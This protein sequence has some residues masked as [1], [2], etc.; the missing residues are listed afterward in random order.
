MEGAVEDY[1]NAFKEVWGIEKDAPPEGMTHEQWKRYVEIRQ[2]AKKL[3]EGAATLVRPRRLPEDRLAL[4]EWLREEAERQQLRVDEFLANFKGSIPE[5]FW[6]DL[7]WAL[8][9]GHPDDPRT[10]RA[11]FDNCMELE[12]LRLFA[13]P[14]D[15]MAERM[16]K[17][18]RVMVRNPGEFTRA[19]LARVAE[20]YVRGM[21]VELAVMARAVIDLALQDVLEDERIRKLF[22]DKERK[23]DIPLARRIQAAASPQIGIL[24]H[25]ARDA[26]DRLREIGNAAAHGGPRAVEKISSAYDADSIL[27]DMAMVLQAIDN[28]HK[29]R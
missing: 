14:P 6:W 20:C 24:D 1:E 17:L 5:D 16:L 13:S 18:L 2:L 29:D 28:A 9:P 26:A 7:Y 15:L 21:L 27:E 11:F 4:L 8:Q 23:E 10:Q 3:A 12:A 25:L 19:Y 22:G